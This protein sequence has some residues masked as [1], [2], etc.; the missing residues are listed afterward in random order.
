MTN[1]FT[2]K[3]TS[4]DDL[5]LQA[6]AFREGRELC[7]LVNTETGEHDLSLGPKIKQE[8]TPKP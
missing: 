7:L 1:D 4:P 3:L 5:K 8:R 2:V 6:Q